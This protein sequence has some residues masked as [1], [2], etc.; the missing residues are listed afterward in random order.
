MKAL[1]IRQP[2]AELI[3]R[4]RKKYEL[5]TWATNHRGRLVIQAG[6]T[7]QAED[8]RKA[9][10]DLADL[11]RGALLGTVEVVDCVP[12]TREMAEELHQARADFD[13]WEPGWHA[14]VLHEPIRLPDPIPYS[15]KMGLF[16]VPDDVLTG[17]GR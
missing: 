13:P 17:A 8:A 12:Y 16:D 1:S 3:L 5:R 9:G 10:L 2:W 6:K 4:G 15:G 7:V 14:W 11:T